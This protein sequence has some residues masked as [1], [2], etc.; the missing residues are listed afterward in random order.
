M[1][2]I[3][4]EKFIAQN[5]EYIYMYVCVCLKNKVIQSQSDKRQFVCVDERQE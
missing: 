1:N 3:D 5:L 2:G 4:T